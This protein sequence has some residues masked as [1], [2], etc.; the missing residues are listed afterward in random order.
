VIAKLPFGRGFVTCDVRGLSLLELRPSLPKKLA[1]PEQLLAQAF[2]APVASKPLAD[3]AAGKKG[4][5]VLV[6]DPTRKA[7]LPKVLPA[8]FRELQQAGVSPAA[9]TLLVACGTHPPAGE[10]LLQEHL[11]PL[12]AGVQVV[13]HNAR[14]QAQLVQ[15]G[16]LLDGT[17]VR[18]NR[19]AVEAPL[20]LSVFPVQHHY[21]AGFGGGPKMVFPGVAGYEEI[22]KNHSRVVDLHTDPPSL[23]PQCQPGIL[24]GNPVAE[25]IA[26]VAALRPVDWAL[27]L[28]LD[29]AQQPLWIAAGQPDRVWQ[30]AIAQVR[31]FFEVPAGPFRKILVSAGG[32]PTDATLIQAHKAMEAAS[33]FLVEGGEMLVVAELSQGAGSPAMEPFLAQPEPAALAAALRQNYVQYGHTTWRLVD[34]AR[35]FRLWLYSQLPKELVLRLGMQPVAHPQEILD[36]WRQEAPRDTVALMAFGLVYPAGR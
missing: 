18:L 9:V 12:P 32:Y 20:L 10:E 23:C 17:P 34:K 5:V 24:A 2:A 35:R 13:Q 1:A 14:D 27:G 30:Q 4:V 31:A 21:F 11:G 26:A 29:Q 28:V 8:L 33:R 16:T 19:V 7:A 36:R 15:V 6:P 25:E 22:Q 3:L